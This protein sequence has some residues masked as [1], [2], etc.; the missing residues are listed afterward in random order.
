[1]NFYNYRIHPTFSLRRAFETEEGS[2]QFLPGDG[3]GINFDIPNEANR[4][5]NLTMPMVVKGLLW[6]F[7]REK[8]EA[9]K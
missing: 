1:M 2:I 3:K 7:E 6:I 9:N 5:F 4:F 8:Q